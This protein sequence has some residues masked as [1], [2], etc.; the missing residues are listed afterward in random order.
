MIAL[1]ER[2]EGGVAATI[3]EHGLPWS[4]TR[5]GCRA[6]YMF[7]AAPAADRRRGRRGARRRAR[8]PAPPLHAQPRRPDDAVSHDGAD[9]ARDRP[10]RTSTAT[11]RRSPRPRPSSPARP[12][13]ERPR[14][15]RDRAPLA[16]R[17]P[18][19]PSSS[20]LATSKTRVLSRTPS[21][22][23]SAG[24]WTVTGTLTAVCPGVVQ[25]RRKC[26]GE[27]ATG[28]TPGAAELVV[29]LDPEPAG[30]V[31]GGDDHQGV[32][33]V[34]LIARQHRRDPVELL[35]GRE[36]QPRAVLVAGVV[37]L[38]DLDRHEEAARGYR[39]MISSALATISCSGT[40]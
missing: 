5:L 10:R 20:F 37:D 28:K 35:A 4:V 1:G 34:A 3:A 17:R 21:S 31:I 9:V 19:S 40:A 15:I 24:R 32:R 8:R 30:L 2:F 12:V 25:S 26:S 27:L 6:E 22:R 23:A 39:S 14:T 16:Q 18:V 11:P 13:A 38:V 33:V 7:S 29:G 36:Q